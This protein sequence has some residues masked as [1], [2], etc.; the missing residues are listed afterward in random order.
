[1]SEVIFIIKFLGS[2]DIKFSELRFGF[3]ELAY[4]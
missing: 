2:C 3:Q 1:M 4:S